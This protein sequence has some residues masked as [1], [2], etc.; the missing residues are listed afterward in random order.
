V[1]RAEFT[2]FYAA[3][4]PRLVGG[5]SAMTADRSEAQDAVQEAFVRAWALPRPD[6]HWPHG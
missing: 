4:F 3:S 1:D 2:S 6:R 5:L